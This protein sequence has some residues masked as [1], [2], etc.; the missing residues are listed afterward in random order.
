M[1]EEGQW[2]VKDQR[3]EERR[4]ETRAVSE[5][6]KRISQSGHET[7]ITQT[8]F[9]LWM[10]KASLSLKSYRFFKVLL[11]F[12]QQY[13]PFSYSSLS[14]HTVCFSEQYSQ[15]ALFMESYACELLRI[16]VCP[17][18]CMT[19]IHCM[20]GGWGAICTH[21]CKPA[22][23]HHFAYTFPPRLEDEGGGANG[24]RAG[25]RK[26]TEWE[27]RGGR[28]EKKEKEGAMTELKTLCLYMRLQAN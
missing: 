13:P 12:Q 24:T 11:G 1:G 5:W 2:A 17:C 27:K 20:D 7:G 6:E 16:Q 14:S 3:D 8:L 10:W 22:P 23:F 15:H 28:R 26:W 9:I 4:K 25:Y 18:E 19:Q 21:R